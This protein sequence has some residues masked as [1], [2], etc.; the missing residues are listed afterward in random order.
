[1]QESRGGHKMF[2]GVITALV[3]PME[4]NGE[5]DYKS[6]EKL[7]ERQISAGVQGLVV[8]G[9]TGESPTVTPQEFEQMLSTVVK[10][11]AKRV[12][13]IAGTGTN[14]TKKTIEASQK[15]LEL[16]ADACLIIAPYYNKPT[17]AGI[18]AH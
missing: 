8:N 17:Q 14:S 10:K 3:T 1:M 15:A 11:A 18:Y 16:G 7:V 13:V 9:S 2:T 5:I 4:A 12:P 6:L